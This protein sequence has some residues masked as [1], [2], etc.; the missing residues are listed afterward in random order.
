MTTRFLFFIGFLIAVSYTAYAE[1]AK[2]NAIELWLDKCARCHGDS[3]KGDTSLG[4]KLKVVDYSSR[5]A[6]E[7]FTDEQL[8]AMILEGKVRNDKKVMPSFKDELSTEE[9]QSL[10]VHIRSLGK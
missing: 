8:H 5:K 7:G 9:I 4:Q 6:Q 3:G 2:T 10:I 1:P